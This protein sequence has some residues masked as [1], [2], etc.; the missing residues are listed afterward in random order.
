MAAALPGPV[1]EED[2][3]DEDD[4]IHVKLHFCIF[5]QLV[6]AAFFSPN[7]PSDAASLHP[8]PLRA[9]EAWLSPS[10]APETGKGQPWTQTCLC[11]FPD[12]R[13]MILLIKSHSKRWN[14][15][16]PLPSELA[17]YQS[18]LSHLAASSLVLPGLYCHL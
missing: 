18:H 6:C 1:S 17:L 12:S 3:D 10:L 16:P 4:D 5:F 9:D 2:E 14:L 15:I 11:P 13:L 7:T 8:E